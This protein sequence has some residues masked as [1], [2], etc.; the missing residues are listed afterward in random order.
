MGRLD[1]AKWCLAG[2]LIVVLV[3]AGI[4]VFMPAK[5]TNAVKLVADNE[6]VSRL[7]ILSVKEAE[8]ERR[9]I[10]MI[11]E[12]VGVSKIDYQP[13]AIL[14]EKDGGLYLPIWIGLLEAS[15][16][17]VILEGAEVPRP[18]TADL[19]CSVIDKMGAKVNYVA[20]NDLKD[21]TFYAKIAINANWQQM[22]IDARPSDAIAIAI[23]VKAPIFVEKAVL[24]QAGILG[25]EQPKI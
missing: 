5:L 20:I 8:Q 13:V 9:P 23:R 14:K 1:K 12:T 18:L 2:C 19:L 10:E 16:I 24:D 15:A 7:R 25:E 11:V 4:S 22:E 21:G 17:S 6:F 3:L